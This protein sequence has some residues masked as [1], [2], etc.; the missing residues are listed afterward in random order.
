[1]AFKMKGSAYKLG[2]VATKAALKQK[3]PMKRTGEFIDTL[4]EDGNVIDTE[5]VI[6]TKERYGDLKDIR[7]DKYYK[8]QQERLEDAQNIDKDTPDNTIVKDTDATYKTASGEIKKQKLRIKN[9]K[10]IIQIH[11]SKI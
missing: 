4:D 3:S 10:Q 11:G 2:N 6:D 9:T 8:K 1:M 5:R 7:G